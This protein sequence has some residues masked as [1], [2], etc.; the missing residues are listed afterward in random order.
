MPAVV[1]AP[2]SVSAQSAQPS[3]SFPFSATDATGT[4]VTVDSEPERVVAL[5]PS[6]AQTMWEIDA[7]G[8]V[9][10]LPIGPTTSY[11]NGSESRTD[12]TGNDG[13]S[14]S[15]ETVVSLE[16]DL[17]LAPNSVPNE[18]VETLRNAGVT[19][20]KF[21]LSGSIADV[22]NKTIRTGRLVGACGAADQRVASLN[23]TVA[24]IESATTGQDRPRVLYVMSGGYTPG[25]GTFIHEII[26][27][28]GGENI[29]ATANI[30][31]YQQINPETVIQQDP[32]WI[33]APDHMSTLP[34]RTAY[35]ATTALEK[36]Q[37]VR[38]DSNYVS[39][40]AP[41]VVRPMETLAQTFHP[42]AFDAENVSSPSDGTNTAPGSQTTAT[43]GPG[44]SV[45]AAVLAV[46]TLTGALFARR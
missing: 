20:Y 6:A 43:T 24:S 27:I 40:P 18:T 30:T 38:V 12:V 8:K 15:I 17:V 23:E 29:A 10:G 39:Q 19:V 34:N 1:G 28:A 7:D 9:V 44:F 11:L 4:N 45:V 21:G 35:A 32:Q 31:G 2:A 3:C 13:F 5:Q 37:T 42:D 36:D 33:I 41:R 26:T 16:P 25:N 46:L 22:S 14:T